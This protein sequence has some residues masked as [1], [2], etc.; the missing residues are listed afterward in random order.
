MWLLPDCLL[1]SGRFHVVVWIAGNWFSHGSHNESYLSYRT[2]VSENSLKV[3][4]TLSCN[5][6]CC[7]CMLGTCE[8]RSNTA[9]TRLQNRL[10]YLMNNFLRPASYIM[11][12]LQSG[13]M[14]GR[15]GEFPFR[16]TNNN[17]NFGT[18]GLLVTST[19]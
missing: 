18:S 9:Y 15:C 11:L 6:S 5:N 16:T 1:S 17:T 4:P 7:S 10:L 19:S 13:G 2:F 8:R 3:S 14:R 12:R